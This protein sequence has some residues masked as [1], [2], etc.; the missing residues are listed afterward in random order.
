MKNLR[1]WI[2]STALSLAAFPLYAAESTAS[3]I[4]IPNNPMLQD[5]FIF[6]LGGFYS[7]NTTS[8][9]LGSPSGG[10]GV[11]VNFEDALDLTDRTLTPVGGFRWRFSDHWRTTVD[12]MNVGR[13]ATNTL[14]SDITWGDQT[15]L[16]GT[17]V[18]STYDFSDLRVSADYAFFKRPDK[19]VGIG[20]GLHVTKIDTSINAAGLGADSSNVTAPLPVFNLYGMFALTDEWMVSLSAD[21]LSLNYDKY[22][23]DIRNM[24]F[25]V[26]YQPFR[27]VGFGVGAR[28]LVIDL[29]VNNPNAQL[30]ALTSFQGP[31]AFITAT[32]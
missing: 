25:T 27:H 30:R 8:A 17:T 13:S 16:K 3:T 28:T 1:Y 9:S 12:Y 26:V 10:A 24:A 4:A 20:I 6:T 2:V 31:T 14:A 11:V 7:R 15:F 5:K 18:S 21:W 23:G 19:E 22:S 32:F 29:T